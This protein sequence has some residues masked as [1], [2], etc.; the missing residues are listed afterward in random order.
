MWMR[1]TDADGA[2]TPHRHDRDRRPAGDGNEE[3][4]L[5]C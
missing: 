2:S 1:D 3:E 4:D 5:T